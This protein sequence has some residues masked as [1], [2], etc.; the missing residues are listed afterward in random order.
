MKKL[1]AIA[2][3]TMALGTAAMAHSGG[4]D[5][6]GGHTDSRTGVYHYH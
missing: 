1:I 4:T 6:Y 3:V 5:S 2:L